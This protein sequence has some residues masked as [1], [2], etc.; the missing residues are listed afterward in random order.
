VRT[1][2]IPSTTHCAPNA[3]A[4][5]AMTSGRAT[6]SELTLTFSAPASRIRS[7]SATD[8]TPPPTANGM[9]TARATRATISRSVG[10]RSCEA[11]MS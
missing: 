3:R 7:M 5:S 11:V 4:P 10:R 9:R 1:G 8:D 2:S 6:A